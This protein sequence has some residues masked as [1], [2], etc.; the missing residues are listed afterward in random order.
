MRVILLILAVVTVLYAY[1]WQLSQPVPTSLPR[2]QSV[3][4]E[5]SGVVDIPSETEASPC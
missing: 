1:A 3:Y 2:M 4:S 5:S